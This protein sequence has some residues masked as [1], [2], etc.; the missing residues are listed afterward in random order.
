MRNTLLKTSAL[1]MAL[2]ILPAAGAFA[3]DHVTK[4]E[5]HRT[6]KHTAKRYGDRQANK[7]ATYYHP[8][9]P[10]YEDS[11]YQKWASMTAEERDLARQRGEIS[12]R[13][14]KDFQNKRSEQ[15]RFNEATNR[16]HPDRWAGKT[17]EEKDAIKQ[18]NSIYER[19]HPRANGHHPDAWAGKTA[20]EKDA[21]QQRNAVQAKKIT[22]YDK[23]GKPIHHLNGKQ[24]IAKVKTQPTA[25][26]DTSQE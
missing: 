5:S 6:Y 15:A 12:Y 11:R 8:A 9:R 20:E 4:Y 17:A 18:R 25:S 16:H 19:S 14:W 3:A 21:I 24:R 13:D 22:V 23:N 1:V 7:P 26:K 2:A 10:N